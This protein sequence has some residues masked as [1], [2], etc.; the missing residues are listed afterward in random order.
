MPETPLTDAHFSDLHFTPEEA[1]MLDFEVVLGPFRLSLR[2][3]DAPALEDD[4]LPDLGS[5]ASTTERAVEPFPYE[6]RAPAGF[7]GL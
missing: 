5:L 6:D 4:T 3:G 2:L 7:R 1:L